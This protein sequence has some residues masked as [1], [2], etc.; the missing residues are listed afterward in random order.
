MSETRFEEKARERREALV[1]CSNAILETIRSYG[2]TVALDV[3][4]RIS[5]YD[6]V[7]REVLPHFPSIAGTALLG[8]WNLRTDSKNGQENPEARPVKT[9]GSRP[10]RIGRSKKKLN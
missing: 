4:V 10:R 7:V 2:F 9:K 5:N 3:A 6:A 1:N 8:T